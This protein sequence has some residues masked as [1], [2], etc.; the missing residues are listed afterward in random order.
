MATIVITNLTDQDV[1]LNDSSYATVRANS[2]VTFDRFL[3]E[4]EVMEQIISLRT[5]G[6]I[7]IS[8][9][10]EPWETEWRNFLASLDS[11]TYALANASQIIHKPT[12]T[13][14]EGTSAPGQGPT[15]LVIGTFLGLHFDNTTDRAYRVMKIDGTFIPGGAGPAGD[16]TNASFHIHWTKAVDTDQSGATVRWRLSYTVSPLNGTDD[17]AGATPTVIE[18]DDTYDDG[19]T[20]SRIV[21]RTDNGAAIGF[22]PLYYV[23]LCLE[24]VPANTTLAGG[25]VVISTDLLFR[26]EIN[27]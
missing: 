26:N 5:Q 10:I 24:Y 16:G 20:T 22:T 15:E 8:V 17:I 12:I 11:E 19:G 23:G 6:V 4:L 3:P 18:W 27:R 1:Y 25:P 21:Y 13:P 7:D 9:T 2:T 14:G